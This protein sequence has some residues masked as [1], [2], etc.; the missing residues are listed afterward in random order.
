MAF[1]EQEEPGCG[2]IGSGLHGRHA[3]G[4]GPRGIGLKTFL[5]AVVV[6]GLGALTFPSNAG[7]ADPAGPEREELDETRREIG[8][9]NDEADALEASDAQLEILVKALLAETDRAQRESVASFEQ[10]A[11]SQVHAVNAQGDLVEAQLAVTE[12]TEGVLDGTVAAY[13]R[14]PTDL[15]GAV[16]LSEDSHDAGRRLSLIS[17]VVDERLNR[18]Y[19]LRNLREDRELEIE[20]VDDILSMN[21]RVVAR[22]EARVAEL[23]V[24]AAE[25]ESAREALRVRIEEINAE[26]ASLADFER[27]L[28]ALIARLERQ[29]ILSARAA[30]KSMAWPASGWVS[31][32]FGVRWG[33]NHNGIDLAASTGSGVIAAAGGVVSHAGPFGSFGNLVIIQHGGGVSTLYAHLH[34]VNVTAGSEVSPGD[35]IATVG[36]T[37]RS[38]GPHLHF[39]VRERG[40]AVNPRVYLQ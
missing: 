19:G 15:L 35:R 38:T 26:A 31:S 33:R 3:P 36:S 17:A 40:R 4:C 12:A 25:Y 32:E 20:I 29:A 23:A 6:V 39:E 14:P 1:C 27:D 21:E 9:L 30:P 24:L 28:V 22:H 16:L 18:L 2:D 11:W 37:G 8:R 10:L 7:A 13:V 5:V 34:S